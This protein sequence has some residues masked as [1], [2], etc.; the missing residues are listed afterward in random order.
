MTENYGRSIKLAANHMTQNMDAYAQQFDLTGTQMSILDF[1]VHAPA[2][3]LQRDIEAEF[4]IRRST[5]TGLLKRM[6]ARD[7]IVEQRYAGDTRQKQVTLTAKGQALQEAT[8]AYIQRSQ[9][10]FV[11]AFSPAARA[12]FSEMLAY[13]RKVSE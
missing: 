3:C 13:W 2:V 1:I 4:A 10:A 12:Q 6:A 7:L 8:S 11:A 9:A 5:A